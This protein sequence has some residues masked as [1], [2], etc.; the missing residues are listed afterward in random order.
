MFVNC[1]LLFIRLPVQ[2][3]EIVGNKKSETGQMEAVFWYGGLLE[4]QVGMEN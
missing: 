2:V 4:E 1:T 3:L